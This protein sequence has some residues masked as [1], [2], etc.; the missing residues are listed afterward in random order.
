MNLNR[1]ITRNVTFATLLLFILEV[2]SGGEKPKTPMQ[3]PPGGVKREVKGTWFRT[4]PLGKTPKRVTDAYPLSDQENKGDWSR[5]ETMSD[6]FNGNQL[7]LAKWSP[8][9]LSSQGRQPG[10]FREANVSVAGG[11]LH[12]VMRKEKVPPEYE[13]RGYHDYTCAK[14][15]SLT[16]VLYG[17]FETR[18]KPMNSAGSSS[19]WFAGSGDG[20][21][22]EIDVFEI[23]GKSKGF[24]QKYN[25]H[26]HVF[27][28]P[29]DKE[30]WKL[31][32]AWIAPW[33]LADDYHVYGLDWSE[34][35]LVCYVDGVAV[36]KVPNTHWHQ[37]LSMIFD[38]ETMG[39]WFGMPDD[40]DLPSTY[41][42]DYVRT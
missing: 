21:R 33:R 9:S 22:T 41:H 37:P 26:L 5:F 11:Q 15:R 32:E 7:D 29:T 17:Y 25:M 10:L 3:P 28:T 16:P 4:E 27:Y 36:W 34:Q 14:A 30:H 8:K 1:H 35:E 40:Q 2:A 38:S 31:G 19:F 18:A 39:D 24:E 20:W 12:L 42:V 13:K 23:G 6:E